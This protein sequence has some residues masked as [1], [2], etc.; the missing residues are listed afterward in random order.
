MSER[1]GTT[2]TDVSVLDHFEVREPLVKTEGNIYSDESAELL[3]RP[4][5][6]NHHGGRHEGGP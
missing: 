3:R 6:Q 2:S 4:Q 1:G 5:R